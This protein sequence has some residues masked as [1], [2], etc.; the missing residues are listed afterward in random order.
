MQQQDLQQ[1]QRMQQQP[2]QKRDFAKEDIVR[3]IQREY[4]SGKQFKANL[5]LYEIC[6]QNENFDV[7]NIS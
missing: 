7:V 1:P 2:E 6:K 5:D 4:T 3:R